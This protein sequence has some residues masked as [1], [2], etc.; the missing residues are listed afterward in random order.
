MEGAE[1]AEGAEGKHSALKISSS[2]GKYRIKSPVLV[3]QFLSPASD[4][5][6]SDFSKQ[7]T[8]PHSS[9]VR[10]FWEVVKVYFRLV[11][12]EGATADRE[13]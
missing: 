6:V 3:K 1:G 4:N 7:L 10:D 2:V 12:S 11:M 8:H 13:K 9:P 5:E